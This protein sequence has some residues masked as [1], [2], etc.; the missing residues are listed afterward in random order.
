MQNVDLVTNGVRNATDICKKNMVGD[1][2]V[3]LL[4]ANYI[5]ISLDQIF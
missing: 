4:I 2:Y 3:V 1:S 5:Y